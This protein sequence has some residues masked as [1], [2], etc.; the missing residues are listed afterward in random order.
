MSYPATSALPPNGLWLFQ[1]AARCLH[2]VKIV[3][4]VIFTESW[5]LVQIVQ[6]QGKSSLACQSRS[7]GGRGVNLDV[8]VGS[9]VR[10]D[11]SRAGSGTHQWLL[12]VTEV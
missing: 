2:V 10:T 7:L 3:L 11:V 12:D 8:I 5:W 4:I 9:E 6:C 1:I